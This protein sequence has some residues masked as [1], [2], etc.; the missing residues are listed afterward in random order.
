M[1]IH[2]IA[3]VSGLSVVSKEITGPPVLVVWAQ[4]IIWLEDNSELCDIKSLS[5]AE[6]QNTVDTN[7]VLIAGVVLSQKQ[8]ATFV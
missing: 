7:V 2:T 5:T 3:M 6:L 8:C 4:R 1:D